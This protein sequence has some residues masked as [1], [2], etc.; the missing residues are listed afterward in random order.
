MPSPSPFEFTVKHLELHSCEMC[1]INK[2]A[3]RYCCFVST[4]IHGLIF[5]T[6]DV[7]TRHLRIH[8]AC[9]QGLH[10]TKDPESSSDTDIHLS[11]FLI[12]TYGRQ[13]QAGHSLLSLLLEVDCEYSQMAGISWDLQM[14]P[15]NIWIWQSDS[16]MVNLS[17][18]TGNHIFEFE[19]IYYTAGNLHSNNK[20]TWL[21]IIMLIILPLE[22]TL[23]KIMLE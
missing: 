20:D 13:E 7:I 11:Y 6:T 3:R 21:Q 23:E 16:E 18:D 8:A 14:T 1:C 5:S 17:W 12:C 15:L 4:A 22:Q 19:N 9:T 2:T 10:K